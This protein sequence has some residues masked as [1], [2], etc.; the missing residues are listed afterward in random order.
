MILKLAGT[1]LLSAAAA[2][3]QT[4]ATTWSKLDFLIGNW[5]GAAGDKDTSLG[6]GQGNFTFA[7]ELDGKVIVRRNFA[8]YTNGVRHDD[9]MVIYRDSPDAGPSAIYFDGEGHVIHY[10]VTFPSPNAAVFESNGASGPNY[11]LTYWMDGGRMR[12]KFEVAPPGGALK[13]YM[14]WISTKN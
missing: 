7:R 1:I 11:R 12:G 13:T 3:A 14:S 5:T 2:L 9:L 10:K 8:A 6:A 4:D